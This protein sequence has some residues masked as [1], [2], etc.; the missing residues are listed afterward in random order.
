MIMKTKSMILFVIFQI[1]VASF[2]LYSHIAHMR[3][4]NVKKKWT[5]DFKKKRTNEILFSICLC[6]S[7]IK[8]KLKTISA[9]P[10]LQYSIQHNKDAPELQW[11]P[12]KQ[13][14][15]KNLFKHTNW[16]IDIQMP[17]NLAFFFLRHPLASPLAHTHT[18][19]HI[20]SV[21]FLIFPVSYQIEKEFAPFAHM[22]TTNI[23][24]G[25]VAHIWETDTAGSWSRENGK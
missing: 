19:Y 9:I 5:K 14:A 24:G 7:M 17:M 10:N 20:H 12:K 8:Q 4:S 25:Q 15:K 21:A 13:Q 16:F 23:V 6:F 1:F 22:D 2:I 3:A 11:N 18:F